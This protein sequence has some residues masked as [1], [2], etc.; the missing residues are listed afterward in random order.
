MNKSVFSKYVNNMLDVL[1]MN[2]LVHG[3]N[4]NGDEKLIEGQR[5]LV[6]EEC[7][8]TITAI[9]RVDTQE[10]VDGVADVFVTASYLAYLTLP[11]MEFEELY[12]KLENVKPITITAE[13]LKDI[14]D[15]LWQTSGEETLSHLAGLLATFE[16]CYYVLGTLDVVHTSNMTKFRKVEDDDGSKE[17]AEALQKQISDDI[18]FIREKKGIENIRVENRDGY[19]IYFNADTG[20]FQKPMCFVEPDLSQYDNHFVLTCFLLGYKKLAHRSD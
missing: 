12:E 17:Y 11:V 13:N 6:K 9:E 3:D 5:K 16:Q 18:A 2:C 20:K 1:R 10:L 7:Q 15:G 8:E 4:R 14:L 19:L